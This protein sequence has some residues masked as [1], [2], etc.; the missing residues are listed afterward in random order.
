[1]FDRTLGEGT[2][3]DFTIELQE[4]AKPYH[5]KTFTKLNIHKPTLKREVDRLIKIQVL[6]KINNSQQADPPLLH[7]R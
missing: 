5:A 4:K 7:L 2:G 1:M 6:W 3:S